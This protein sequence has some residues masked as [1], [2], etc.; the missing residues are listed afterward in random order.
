MRLSSARSVILGIAAAFAAIPPPTAAA[1]A[2]KPGP[3]S[4]AKVRVAQ[5]ERQFC[6]VKSVTGRGVDRLA[7]KSPVRGTISVRTKG[8]RGS[9]WDLAIVNVKRD[10]VI[11]GSA[12]RGATG[13]RQRSCA[14]ASASCCRPAGAT[15]PRS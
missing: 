7:V 6:A 14:R 3:V 1:A 5:V 13:T 2:P 9:D 15:A 11:T 4:T 8:A 12:Q 10:Q